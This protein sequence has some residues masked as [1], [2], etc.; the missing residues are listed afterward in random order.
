MPKIVFCDRFSVKVR[1]YHADNG[2]FADQGFLDSLAKDQT[3]S[4]CGAYAHWQNGKAE[5]RIRD[6]QDQGRKVLIYST[7][8]WP[9][10]SN[11]N[12]W[13]YAL[14]YSTDVRNHLPR[15]ESGLSPMQ[16]YTGV[17]VAPRLTTFHTFGCP[18]Y[19]LRTELQNGKKIPKWDPRCHVGLYLGNSPRY[20]RLVSNVLN[21]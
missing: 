3:I 19:Q 17:N 18:V 1:H 12:L 10:A 13:P 16:K 6:L 21:L 9:Q 14:H 7:A 4:F 8:R 5:K 20:S 2:R 15:D 11:I